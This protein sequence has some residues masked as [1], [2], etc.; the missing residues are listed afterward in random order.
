LDGGDASVAL[1]TRAIEAAV[2]Q[3]IG[4]EASITVEDVSLRLDGPSA[5]LVAVPVPEAR[6]G[7]P[8]RFLLERRGARTRGERVGEATATVRAVASVVRTSAPIRRGEFLPANRIR[9]EAVDLDGR[10]LRPLPG[11]GECRDAR[12]RRDLPAG[13]V[14]TRA[15][16]VTEP[17]VR[18]GETV[19]TRVR[20]GDVTVA[21]PMIAAETGRKGDVIR[22]LNERTRRSVRAEVTG[23]REVEVVD[24]R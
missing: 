2:R 15:D 8:S 22:V 16:I 18:S 1:A 3:R 24:A 14:V 12:T 13:A 5:G 23:I 4:M 10:P 17:L 11:L 20:I 21:G 6:I 9:V 19:E 7:Q